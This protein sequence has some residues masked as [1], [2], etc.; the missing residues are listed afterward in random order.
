MAAFDQIKASG[1]AGEARPVHAGLGRGRLG[2]RTQEFR[3]SFLIVDVAPHLQVR[4]GGAQVAVA[5]AVIGEGR[6]APA[7]APFPKIRVA[8]VDRRRRWRRRRR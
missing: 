6:W 2:V 4:F 1:D 8:A 3:I 5:A 7:T